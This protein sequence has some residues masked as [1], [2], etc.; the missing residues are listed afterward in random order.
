M[1]YALGEFITVAKSKYPGLIVDIFNENNKLRLLVSIV[2]YNGDYTVCMVD[3]NPKK[4]Q[5]DPCEKLAIVGKF[6]D[7]FYKQ[8]ASIYQHIIIENINK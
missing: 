7:W 1:S 4:I 8:H 3:N 2:E 6:D 5:L